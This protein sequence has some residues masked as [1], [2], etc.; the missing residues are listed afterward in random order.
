MGRK[1]KIQLVLIGIIVLGTAL[2]LWLRSVSA[3]GGRIWIERPESGTKKQSISF[4]TKSAEELFAFEIEARKRTPEEIEEAYAET[5]RQLEKRI[6]PEGKEKIVL[7]EALSLPQY[8]EETGA[9][10]RW[11]SSDEEVI[12]KDGRLR[13]EGLT[14]ERGAFLRAR[15]TIE[16]ECREY[17]L[18]VTVLP[19]EAESSEALF[20]RAGEEL[21]RLEQE[22]AGEDGFYLPERIGAVAVTLPEDSVFVPGMAAAAVL[23]LAVL[24]IAAK[25][26]EKEKE[27]QKR[28]EE[29]LAGY[30][31]LITKLTLYVG[32]GLSLRG[33][34]ERLAAEYRKRAEASGKREA[35]YEEVL[36][37][38]GE[39]KNGKSEAGAY[40]AFGRRIGLKPYLRCAAL[41]ISQLQKGSGGLREGL[42]NEVRLA[43]ELHRQQAEKQ[44]EEAQTK[45]LFPMMGMLLLVLAVVMF[46]AFCNM[47]F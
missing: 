22:T 20:Y 28:E 30:P 40:E 26:R 24:I 16:D 11:E 46:P 21:K 17:W 13:R 6:N 3:V 45:L 31:Q 12:T 41:L 39:L 23:F 19:Y 9:G 43:W 44:G 10:I 18:S 33:A 8:I 4:T 47:G 29:F 1:E 2:F 32:A 14:E 36:V 15:I 5:L 27:K 7:T 34:W 35:V 38:A 25:R 42:E 37:L